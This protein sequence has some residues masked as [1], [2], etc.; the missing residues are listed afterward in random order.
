MLHGHN[1]MHPGFRGLFPGL[2][3]GPPFSLSGGEAL[4]ARIYDAV[5]SSVILPWLERL[6]HAA[7]GQPRRARRH[8]RPCPP[9]AAPPPDPA[10]PPGQ[11]GFTFDRSGVRLP[12]V[13]VSP[14][15][16]SG[17]L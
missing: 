10:A 15:I 5:R 7:Y 9:P 13:A 8:L 1:D 6:Q 3:Y 4:L 14:W 12:A 11:H 16:P 17:P 2:A